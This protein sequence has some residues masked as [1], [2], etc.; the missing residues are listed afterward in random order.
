MI[1]HVCWSSCKV[2]IIIFN[3][4]MKIKF[5][6]QIFIK[7]QY[8]KFHENSSSANRVVPCGQKGGRTDMMKQIVAFGNF[9]NVLKKPLE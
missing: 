4:L 1:K 3:I 5:S 9:A 6:L 7:Y 8:I 2:H